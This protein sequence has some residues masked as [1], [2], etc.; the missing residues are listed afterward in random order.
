M[1]EY[2]FGHILGI[3]RNLFAGRNNQPKKLWKP[4]TFYP[5]GEKTRP[6]KLSTL[7]LGLLGC[8]DIGS[9]VAKTAKDGF[10]MKVVVYKRS[11]ASNSNPYVDAIVT[12]EELLSESDYIVNTLPS[13]KSTIGLLNDEVFRK[14][15]VQQKVGKQGPVF[16]NVGRVSAPLPTVHGC[17]TCS[18]FRET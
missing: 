2:V 11:K 4:E 6:R 9:A 14:V 17:K 5:V 8:G 13:T 3:E 18:I 12:L 1:S 10:G 16:I 7:T 15:S